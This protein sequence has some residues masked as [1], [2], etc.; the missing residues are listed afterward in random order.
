MMP[1]HVI[2]ATGAGDVKLM[3]A[4][5]AVVGPHL[6]VKVFLYT[7][8]AGGLFALAVATRR[9]SLMTTL[10]GTGRLVTA[11][12]AARH[13]I[14][15]PSRGNRST[16]YPPTSARRNLCRLARLAVDRDQMRNRIF[17]VLAIAV[18]AGGGL[19]H[20]TYNVINA[21]QAK[22]AP[23]PTQPVV[24]AAGDLQ[25]GAELEERR[26]EDRQLS[27]GPGARRPSP[28]RRTSSAAASSARW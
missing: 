4:I 21:P 28:R 1:G 11:P 14:E 13:P 26:S 3:A 8:V 16:L 20:G 24:V 5:G 2:G 18:L 12:V 7:A 23:A 6:I 27:A 17:A 22:A 10:A 9:G 19:A 15:S 25:L